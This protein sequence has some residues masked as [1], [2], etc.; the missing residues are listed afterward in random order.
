MILILIVLYDGIVN[1][2]NR[3]LLINLFFIL[4]DHF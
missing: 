4:F 3:H 2:I 1:I